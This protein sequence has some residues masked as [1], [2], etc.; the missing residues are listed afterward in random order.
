MSYSL[1]I[2]DIRLPEYNVDVVCRSYNEAV[3]VIYKQ[4]CPYFIDFDHDL[5]TE[6]TGYDFAKLIVEW[7]MDGKIQI[8]SN[9]TF[10]V[11]S[12]NPV[13]AENIKQYLNNYLDQKGF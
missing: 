8:P 9:F 7:D 1:Y 5:A 4:G 11:H 6:K 10:C 3:L 13:G 2:D 12:A